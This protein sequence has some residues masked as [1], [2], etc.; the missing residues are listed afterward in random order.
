MR[1]FTL[2]ARLLTAAVFLPEGARVADIGTDH[3][4]LPI[5]LLK[6]GRADSVMA[7]DIADDPIRRA[8]ENVERWGVGTKVRLLQCAGFDGYRPEDFTH[9][10]ICGMGG[11]T[12]AAILDAA[13]WTADGAH[14]LILQPET[15]AR[16]LREYLY[17]HHFKIMDEI[18]VIDGSRVY[19]VLK[20]TGGEDPHGADPLYARISYPLSLQ[21]D[22][23]AGRYF[24]RARRSLERE[25]QGMAVDSAAYRDA[26]ALLSRMR[27][28]EAQN[29]K[30]I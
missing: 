25:M 9:G 29:A 12:I 23:A 7:S 2:G 24:L 19:T 22:E 8:R 18:A 14:T 4:R 1:L 20:V 10:V 17:T 21:R 16:R 27:E 28:L 30:G 5:W 11:D 26:E 15:A 13:P 3:A 6:T